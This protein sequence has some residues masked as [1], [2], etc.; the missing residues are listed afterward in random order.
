MSFKIAV[1]QP[2]SHRPPDD[3]QNVAD[4][5]R[6]IESAAAGGAR[7]VAFPESY[8]GPWPPSRPRFL[9]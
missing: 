3:E 4:A 6:H 2:M 7:F 1:V 5:I 9:R 8:P